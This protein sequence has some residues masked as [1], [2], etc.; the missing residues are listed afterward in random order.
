[1]LLSFAP[2][3]RCT[4]VCTMCTPQSSSATDPA[5]LSR[6]S[7][8][9]MAV[10]PWYDWRADIAAVYVTNISTT[11]WLRN[12]ITRERHTHVMTEAEIPR[13]WIDGDGGPPPPSWG[14]DSLERHA[15]S[16]RVV[17]RGVDIAAGDGVADAEEL[18]AAVRVGGD[19]LGLAGDEGLDI[20][21]A[22]VA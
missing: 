18:E 4:P 10:A 16:Q 22:A 13:H 14:G 19:R 6:T 1:K 8:K 15:Q 17:D 21:F 12:G 11:A 2:K 9:S 7:R 5:R 20:H 3:A